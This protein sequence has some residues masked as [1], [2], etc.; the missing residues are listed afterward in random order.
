MHIHILAIGRWRECPEKTLFQEYIK[1]IGWKCDLKEIEVKQVLPAD[2]LK[3]KEAELLLAAIPKGAAII[4]LDE[5]GKQLTSP[6]FSEMLKTVEESGRDI[7]FLIGGASGHGEA[8]L[9][10]AERKLSLGAMTWPHMMVRAMLSEQIYRA[11]AILSGHPY[12]RG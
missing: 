12:H 1:R 8:V 7:A 2:K 4:V 3:I 10:A 9:K 11:H 6:Q 5:H